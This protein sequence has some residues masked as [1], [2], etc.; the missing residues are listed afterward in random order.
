MGMPKIFKTRVELAKLLLNEA[1]QSGKC[2]NL[3]DVFITGPHPERSIT[4]EF[5]TAPTGHATVSPECGLEL[6][7]IRQPPAIRVR[8]IGG[9]EVRMLDREKNRQRRRSARVYREHV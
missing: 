1:R 3:A 6:R 4:W 2:T 5:V 8:S 9:L 7:A